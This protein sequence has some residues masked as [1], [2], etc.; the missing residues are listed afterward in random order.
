MDLTHTSEGPFP[1]CMKP[2]VLHTQAD[3]M[4]MEEHLNFVTAGV[5]INNVNMRDFHFTSPYFLHKHVPCF[6][7][8]SFK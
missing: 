3:G 7:R 4:H 1:V 2:N 6:C 5:C 8:A